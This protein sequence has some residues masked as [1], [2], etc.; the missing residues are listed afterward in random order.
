MTLIEMKIENRFLFEKR[1][2]KEVEKNVYEIFKNDEKE[3]YIKFYNFSFE[4]MMKN[5]E[6]IFLEE[7]EEVLEEEDKKF[8]ENFY[9]DF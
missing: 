3:S 9:N 7:Y 6:N 5:L 2:I 1:V 8:Q 4:E